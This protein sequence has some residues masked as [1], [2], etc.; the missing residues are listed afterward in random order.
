MASIRKALEKLTSVFPKEATTEGWVIPPGAIAFYRDSSTRIGSGGFGE[1]FCG[2]CY[3]APCAVKVLSSTGLLGD[4]A[5]SQ[6]VLD[7]LLASELQ[8]LTHLRSSAHV[9]P[10]W[11]V[12]MPDG[13]MYPDQIW[14]VMQLVRG[15]NV[16]TLMEFEAV[17]SLD[18]VSRVALTT[19]I[20][21]GIARCLN[22]IHAKGVCHMDLKPENVMISLSPSTD[23]C[24]SVDQRLECR[25]VDFG[26]AQMTASL[27]SGATTLQTATFR[28]MTDEYAATELIEHALGS[29]SAPPLTV[30]ADLYS[31]AVMLLKMASGT[32]ARLLIRGGTPQHRALA[33]F[34]AFPEVQ[35][36]LAQCLQHEVSVF[37]LWLDC[38]LLFCAVV[39]GLGSSDRC[40]CL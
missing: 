40:R 1:V 3:G 9:A 26:T 14:I 21:R 24:A 8:S 20:G 4:G 10:M 33:L 5:S 36:C 11:G 12:C 39:L 2:T 29:S 15:K 27:R 31:F 32:P 18:S 28:A 35:A 22:Y 37:R 6:I 16:R 30:R 38:S 34:A 13:I 19:V 25:L 17:K 23:I 7:E